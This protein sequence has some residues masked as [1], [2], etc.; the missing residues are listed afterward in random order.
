MESNALEKSTKC[1]LEIFCAYS[2]DNSLISQSLR[3]GRLIYLKTVLI[4]SKNFLSSWS[5]TMEKQDII[6]FCSKSYDFV[7]LSDSDTT[8]L[9]RRSLSSISLLCFVHAR[10]CII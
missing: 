6:D 3:S 9:K 1:C 8:F 2:F 7:V 5:D 4:F 10:C